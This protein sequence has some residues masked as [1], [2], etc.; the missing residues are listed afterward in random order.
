MSKATVTAPNRRLPGHRHQ[1]RVAGQSDRAGQPF[2]LLPRGCRL[3][4]F[5]LKFC[6]YFPYNAKLCINGHEWAKRQ[7]T[8]S[9]IVFTALDDSFAPIEGPD[10]VARV[11]E[12]CDLLGPGTSTRY[13]GNG[14][15][16]LPHPFT[17]LTCGVP[18][19]GLRF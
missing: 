10:E 14:W 11:Q 18:E 13:Y 2:L 7:A 6:S 8:K 16:S 12:I 19:V 17:P 4:P 1:L 5:V 9:G 15:R 3:R